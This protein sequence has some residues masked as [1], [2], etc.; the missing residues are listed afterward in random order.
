MMPESACTSPTRTRPGSAGATRTP[1][2][3]C[4]SIS[5][6]APTSA[7]GANQ[8]CTHPEY[9]RKSARKR[10][11]GLAGERGR[12]WEPSPAS[13]RRTDMKRLCVIVVLGVLLVG[14]R[15]TDSP[16]SAGGTTSGTTGAATSGLHGRTVMAPAPGCA[17]QRKGVPCPP[18]DVAAHIEV[19]AAGF[20]RIVA[21]ADSSA[22]GRFTID[23]PAGSYTVTAKADGG[24]PMA[25]TQQTAATVSAGRYT[26]LVITFDSGIRG[27]AVR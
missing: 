24:M 17:V 21:Q 6:R 15:T 9:H 16:G 26:P 2:A 22:D 14:C 20:S 4:G 19:R 1:T 13:T 10:L 27:P 8:N 25:Q 18:L 11:S 5:P 12:G 23:L 3:C 7:D